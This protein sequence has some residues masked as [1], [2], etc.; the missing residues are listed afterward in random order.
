MKGKL[1]V[2]RTDALIPRGVAASLFCFPLPL[3]VQPGDLPGPLLRQGVA[4]RWRC[5]S[6]SSLRRWARVSGGCVPEGCCPKCAAPW[7][8][9]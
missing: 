3:N 1:T 6:R 5:W 9:A 8:P 7:P 2:A 4:A